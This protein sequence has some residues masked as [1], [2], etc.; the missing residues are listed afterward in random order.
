M[1]SIRKILQL[2]MEKLSLG[3]IGPGSKERL[4]AGSSG[5]W[6]SW[7]T[8]EAA[9][10][11]SGE[12]EGRHRCPSRLQRRR[13]SR[14]SFAGDTG[15]RSYDPQRGRLSSWSTAPCR[16]QKKL[17]GKEAALNAKPAKRTCCVR[18]STQGKR[19]RRGESPSGP[20]S[21]WPLGGQSEM[22]KL[23]AISNKSELH[24]G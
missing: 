16:P 18:R 3:R 21:R 12:G 6:R 4:E 15:K 14:C 8:A 9:S 19:H 7:A 17:R 23:L 10:M 24:N 2:E 22:E 1:R 11:P 20:A 13:S 5:N